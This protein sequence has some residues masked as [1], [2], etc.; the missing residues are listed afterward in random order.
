MPDSHATLRRLKTRFNSWRGHR[1]DGSSRVCRAHGGLLNRKAGFDSRAGESRLTTASM[2]VR[3]LLP[4]SPRRQLAVGRSF[5]ASERSA[6]SADSDSSGT[7]RAP[8]S[9]RNY[10]R[11]PSTEP[12]RLPSSRRV[13]F[14]ARRNTEPEVIGAFK[15]RATFFFFFFSSSL[16]SSALT[17]GQKAI[18]G[19]AFPENLAFVVRTFIPRLASDNHQVKSASVQ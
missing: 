12:A 5:D 16:S 2:L 6:K 14:L 17:L 13:V 9:S 1:S 7:P 19:Q 8:L 4:E 11:L 10:R 18:L 3:V 15:M